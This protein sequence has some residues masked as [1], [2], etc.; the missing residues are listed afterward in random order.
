MAA[1][2]FFQKWSRR[3]AE[4]REA[5]QASPA[6]TQAAPPAPTEPLPAPTLDDVAAL[7]PESDFSRFVARDVDEGVRRSAMKKLFTDPH[8]NVMDGLDIYIDDYTKSDP[9]P[10]A[11][12]AGLL[13][14]KSVLNPLDQFGKPLLSLLNAPEAEK[15]DVPGSIA[16]KSA[17]GEAEDATEPAEAMPEAAQADAESAAAE[18]PGGDSQDEQPIQAAASGQPPASDQDTDRPAEAGQAPN[19][20]TPTRPSDEH[21]I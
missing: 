14:A 11:M 4:A 10:A 21:E 6:E 20:T 13:H 17:D 12:L 2:S 16:A 3:K 1:E 9:I 15:S 8:F 18:Q 7:T 5:E 19:Q